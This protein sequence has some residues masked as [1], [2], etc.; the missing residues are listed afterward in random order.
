MSFSSLISLLVF[1]TSRVCVKNERCFII[2]M[3]V[4]S[5]AYYIDSVPIFDL[6]WILHH[7]LSAAH[8]LV[9]E[10]TFT[11]L[12]NCRTD[13]L[14]GGI[15]VGEMCPPPYFKL[16]SRTTYI[17][18][19]VRTVILVIYRPVEDTPLNIRTVVLVCV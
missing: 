17:N 10:H 15:V 16:L 2:Q 19:A 3:I 9:N 13:N 18:R 14:E 12:A 11:L 7:D 8:M 5:L 4:L 1:T 6:C